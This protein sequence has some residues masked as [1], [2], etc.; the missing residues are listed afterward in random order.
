M[1]SPVL[2]AIDA[3][4]AS[5]ALLTLARRYCRPGEH[6]LHVLLAIDS[7]FAVHDQ[8]A[9]YTA[10][11]LEEYPAACEEQQHADHAVA[12]AVRA[13]QQAGFASQGCMVAGQPVEVI[14]TKAQELNCELIIM[15]HRH[16]SRLGRLLDP[17]I[18]AK[19]IDRVKVPV[20]VGAAGE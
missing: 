8:P 11:E 12:E 16:L 17:S 1:P 9:P 5:S 14:V 10:E 15:G 20:L 19:V 18:S 7:T 6:E 4:P 2:I 13:L 3:S